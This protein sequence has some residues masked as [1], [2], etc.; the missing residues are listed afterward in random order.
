MKFQLVVNFD[1]DQ[2][3]ISLIH[4]CYDIN[5]SFLFLINLNFC[6]VHHY[7]SRESNLSQSFWFRARVFANAMI[8]TAA[9]VS[10]NFI[11]GMV[12]KYLTYFIQYIQFN[13]YTP[14]KHDIRCASL[15]GVEF[16]VTKKK[17]EKRAQRG[18]CLKG[19]QRL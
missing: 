16:V 7:V 5:N 6:Q 17:R 2:N 12:V 1:F 9:G 3:S 19:A 4:L 15:C 13:L 8:C 14:F 10:S 11:W 18:S